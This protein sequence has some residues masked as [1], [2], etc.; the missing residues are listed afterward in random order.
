MD[1]LRRL[2]SRKRGGK[3][4]TDTTRDRQAFDRLVRILQ[5]RRPESTCETD[6][7]LV[8]AADTTDVLETL[9]EGTDAR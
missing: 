2:T 8:E 6:K 9:E 7:R 4:G 3:Y 5:Y 1:R